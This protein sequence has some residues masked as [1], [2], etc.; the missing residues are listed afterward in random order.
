MNI[1]YGMAGRYMTTAEQKKLQEEVLKK[2]KKE[3][4]EEILAEILERDKEIRLSYSEDSIYFHTVL[5]AYAL[6]KYLGWGERRL[7]Q[8]IG[9]V[10]DLMDEVNA[11]KLTLGDCEKALAEKGITLVKSPEQ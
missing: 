5:Y 7:F 3:L 9:Y 10:A 1:K 2:A 6:S 4:R 11:G 8:I